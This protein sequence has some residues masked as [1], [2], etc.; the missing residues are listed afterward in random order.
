MK[1]VQSLLLFFLCG[2]VFGQLNGSWQGVL[3]QD[4]QNG[5]TTNF[6][7]WVELIVDGNQLKG[8]FRSEQANSPYYK[9][10]SIIGKIEGANIVV[11][12]QVIVNEN[13]QKGMGW[14]LLLARFVYNESE[15]KLKGTYT[16]ATKGCVA[17]ELVLVKSNKAFN[18]AAT[19]IVESS[20]LDDVKTLLDTKTGVVGKQFVLTDVNFQSG[21]HSITSSSYSY[22]KKITQL[23]QENNTIKIH[24]KGHTDS[25]GDDENNF[26]LSQKRAKSVSDYLIKKGIV[27]RRITFEGYGESRSIS[28]NETKEG[29]KENRRVELLIVSE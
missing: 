8:S 23:L 28:T 25:D 18:R 5:T 7:V 16:S 22:L 14:C 20:S 4:N 9:I 29:K 3:I 2:T 21:K 6:A 24:L 17:G 19:E 27:K 15:Q 26:I 13:T 10:S 12:E 1:Y 11:K